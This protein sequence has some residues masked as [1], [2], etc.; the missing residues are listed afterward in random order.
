[1]GSSGSGEEA[2]RPLNWTPEKSRGPLDFAVHSFVSL[3][4][5]CLLRLSS[6]SGSVVCQVTPVDGKRGPFLVWGAYFFPLLPLLAAM[7]TIQFILQNPGA[8]IIVG[9]VGMATL[10]VR[11][12]G[13][14]Y[15]EGSLCCSCPFISKRNFFPYHLSDAKSFRNS[16]APLLHQFLF[17][18]LI[19][20]SKKYNYIYFLKKAT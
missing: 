19:K 11:H 16:W 9:K 8:S 12:L 14:P 6:S 15:K 20:K 5:F 7:V 3:L 10:S 2:I 13:S 1:M 17:L 18:F 4:A